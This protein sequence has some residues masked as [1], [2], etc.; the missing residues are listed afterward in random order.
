M[1]F[2]GLTTENFTRDHSRHIW[3]CR[4]IAYLDLTWIV[5]EIS[6]LEHYR[7][8]VINNDDFK[9]YRAINPTKYLHGKR[10]SVL[11]YLT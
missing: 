7:A 10:D 3:D 11:K 5:P 6:Y 8:D 4:A 9:R 1:N 2:K